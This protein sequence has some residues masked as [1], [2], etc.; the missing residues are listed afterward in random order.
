VLGPNAA[1]GFLTGSV[2]AIPTATPPV[3]QVVGNRIVYQFNKTGRYLVVC[4]N[5]GHLLNDHM[6]GFVSVVGDDEDN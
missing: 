5:R 6:F 2:I 1:G 4:M 3:A